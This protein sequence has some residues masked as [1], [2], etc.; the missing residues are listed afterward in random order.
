MLPREKDRQSSANSLWSNVW[1]LQKYVYSPPRCA[2][3]TVPSSVQFSQEGDEGGSR[4]MRFTPGPRLC[5]TSLNDVVFF[6]FFPLPLQVP[7]IN[8]DVQWR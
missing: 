6:F 7:E 4:G 1:I 5:F 3:Q 2:A 8:R